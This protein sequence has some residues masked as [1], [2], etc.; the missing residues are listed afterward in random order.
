LAYFFDPEPAR[1]R[2]SARQSEEGG[3]FFHLENENTILELEA[4]EVLELPE[5]YTWM[6]LAQLLE[7]LKVGYLS[8]DARTLLACASLV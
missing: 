5:H 6:T 3:R 2:Y 8:V 7:F 1:V 4:N